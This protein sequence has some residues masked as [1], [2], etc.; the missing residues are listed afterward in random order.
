MA[1]YGSELSNGTTDGKRKKRGW[2][3]WLGGLAVLG[4]LAD[5]N[6]R[7]K[8]SVGEEA[9]FRAIARAVAH[10]KIG[11]YTLYPIS[12]TNIGTDQAGVVQ[13]SA[14]VAAD[15]GWKGNALGSVRLRRCRATVDQVQ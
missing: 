8:C 14:A 4:I 13:F 12:L 11:D 5:D 7:R 15:N 2:L 6:D 10:W 3:W 1:E 9:F